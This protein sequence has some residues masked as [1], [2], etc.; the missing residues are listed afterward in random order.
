MIFL[1]SIERHFVHKRA[2]VGSLQT[3]DSPLQWPG[4]WI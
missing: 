1:I 3:N 2:A 4:L